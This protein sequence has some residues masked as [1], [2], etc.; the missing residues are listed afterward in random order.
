MAVCIVMEACWR[1][2]SMIV[3]TVAQHVMP[4]GCLMGETIPGTR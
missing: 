1:H 3:V 4:E 2:I